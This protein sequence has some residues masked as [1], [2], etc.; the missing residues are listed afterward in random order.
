M[1]L[2]RDWLIATGLASEDQ[3]ATM[4]AAIEREIDEAVEFTLNSPYPD[5]AELKRD[6]YKDEVTV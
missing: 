6:I 4:E 5:V 2:F 1:P 3:L